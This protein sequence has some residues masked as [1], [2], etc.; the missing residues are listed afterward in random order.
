MTTSTNQACEP[1]QFRLP[2]PG[3]VDQWWQAI[4]PQASSISF[5]ELVAVHA[6]VFGNA[7]TDARLANTAAYDFGATEF[8]KAKAKLENARR[9][10]SGINANSAAGEFASFTKN[11]AERRAGTEADKRFR[12]TADLCAAGLTVRGLSF[13][14]HAIPEPGSAALFSQPQ[15]AAAQRDIAKFL[16][17]I[18]LQDTGVLS[19][20]GPVSTAARAFLR[21]TGKLD[22]NNKF[23]L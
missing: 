4:P 20:F 17:A 3:E 12:L 10:G 11:L 5:A 2:R 23:T 22:K 8:V 7:R 6:L 16:A 21:E 15:R 19:E 13:H 9:P 18:R 14:G 1:V